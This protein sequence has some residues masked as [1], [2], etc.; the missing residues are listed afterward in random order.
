M[1]RMY[2]RQPARNHQHSIVNFTRWRGFVFV[3]LNAAL[4]QTVL[5]KNVFKRWPMLGVDGDFEEFEKG[6]VEGICESIIEKGVD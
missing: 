4:N 5:C 3:V 1:S 6:S 2:P